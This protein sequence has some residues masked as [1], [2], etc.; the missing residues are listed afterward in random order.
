M[1]SHTASLF[2]A[3]PVKRI[4]DLAVKAQESSGTILLDDELRR[5]I[6]T[7]ENDSSTQWVCPIY[8]ATALLD[9]AGDAIDSGAIESMPPDFQKTV[10]RAAA[11]MN[12]GEYLHTMAGM[13]RLLDQEGVPD[14]SELPMAP[15]E[16]R[17]R[18]P[19]LKGFG[20]NWIYD[21]DYSSLAESTAAAIAS[22]HPLCDEFLSPLA[23]EAQAA[24][25]LFPDPR[26]M[27][28]SLAREIEWVSV[29]SLR[30]LVTRINEHMLE[31][32]GHR[33]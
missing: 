4:L 11:G 29:S 8:T 16:M 17:V 15:W 20:V 10:S 19:G 12:C 22:E 21:G 33:S 13:I 1:Q 23:A 24:L 7:V 5:F 26:S 28:L 9:L 18:F 25:V 27:Q 32:H 6:R 30:E 2:N 3:G 31:E 14:Y